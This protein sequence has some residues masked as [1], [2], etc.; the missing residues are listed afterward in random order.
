MEVAVASYLRKTLASVS[1]VRDDANG[2]IEID[3]GD[4]AFGALESGETAKALVVYV[5]IGGDDTTPENDILVAHIDTA[6]GLPLTL[7]GGTVSISINAE[8]LLQH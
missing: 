2:R 6:T 4:V 8:G 1:I 5:Q 7:N 3:L